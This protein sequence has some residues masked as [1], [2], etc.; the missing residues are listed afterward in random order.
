MEVKIAIQAV[1]NFMTQNGLQ[2]ALEKTKAV[3]LAGGR[4]LLSIN[5]PVQCLIVRILQSIKYLGVHFDQDFSTRKHVK[6]TANKARLIKW[7]ISRVVPKVNFVL[8]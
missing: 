2:I 4:T 8:L 1:I 6:E 7:N 5:I 3:T